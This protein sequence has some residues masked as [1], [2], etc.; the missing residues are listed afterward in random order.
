MKEKQ[1]Q[2]QRKRSLSVSKQQAIRLI[3]GEYNVLKEIGGA[4]AQE[5]YCTMQIGLYR[6]KTV[7]EYNRLA[8]MVKEN[9]IRV[10]LDS[11]LTATEANYDIFSSELSL[12]PITD[13]LVLEVKYNHFLLDYIKDILNLS[14]KEEVAISK[15]CLAR[16][17]SYF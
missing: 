1:G 8:Y 11:Q 14:N 7:V 5:F 10:T 17:I 15:Y 3:Q 13:Q 16:Q 6:P 9:N 12:Y 2:N 4:L